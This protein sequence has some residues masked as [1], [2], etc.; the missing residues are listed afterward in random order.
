MPGKS[1]LTLVHYPCFVTPLI[2]VFLFFTEYNP[3]I[4]SEKG[5]FGT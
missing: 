2:I 1:H 4:V 5:A 3:N